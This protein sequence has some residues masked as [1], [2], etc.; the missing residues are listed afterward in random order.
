MGDDPGKAQ[1]ALRAGAH[2]NPSSPGL[3]RLS[4]N[5]FEKPCA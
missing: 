4:I 2:E 5:F 1:H 3:A